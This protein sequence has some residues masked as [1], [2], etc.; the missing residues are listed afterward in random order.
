[1]EATPLVAARPVQLR[2][3]ILSAVGNTPLVGLPRLSPPG[4]NLYAKLEGMNPTGSVKD[5]PALYMLEAAERRGELQPGHHL[6]EPTSGNT[7]LSLAMIAAV[8]GYRLTVVAPEN[9]PVEKFQL[10]RLYGADVVSSPA[11]QGSNGAIEL[12]RELDLDRR[13]VWML[14][15]YR[16]PAGVEAHY[17]TTGPEIL[18]QLPG[19]TAFV[20]GLGS[21]GTLMGV[22]RRLK[23]QDP[24]IDVIAAEPMA[25]ERVQ[26][27]RSMAEGF[28]PPIFDPERLNG[29]Y[30]IDGEEALSMT[31][32][33]LREEGIFA[34]PSSGAALVAALRYARMKPGGKIVVL[35]ADGGWKYVSTGVYDEALTREASKA[36]ILW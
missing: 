22:S 4:T 5:R 35:L 8:K 19:I 12:A 33:L 32:R 17:Q 21:G 3:G 10:L 1:V 25:G 31:R 23:E 29:R 27:L 16:N 18:D 36:S 20:A 24:S 34:G 30:L 28:V 11:D 2:V 15:Q 14:D 6:L 26:G 7:G 9:V 13:D